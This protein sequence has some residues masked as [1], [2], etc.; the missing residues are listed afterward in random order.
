MLLGRSVGL[1]TPAPEDVG[2]LLRFMSRFA[3]LPFQAFL[4]SGACA[5]SPTERKGGRTGV[6]RGYMRP[7]PV[8]ERH[9]H[10]KSVACLVRERRSRAAAVR[11][12]EERRRRELRAREERNKMGGCVE[13]LDP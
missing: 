2:R 4:A 11:R 3:V 5:V 13:T 7:E 10:F 9:R 1:P 8:E 12:S 6:S